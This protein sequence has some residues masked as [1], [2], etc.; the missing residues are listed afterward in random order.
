MVTLLVH[1]LLPLGLG[2]GLLLVDAR[3]LLPVLALL[4]S[5]FMVEGSS[6]DFGSPFR[7]D[8]ALVSFPRTQNWSSE[9]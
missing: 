3:S 8:Q 5:W 1:P 6:L 7:I 4:P 2:F 9:P